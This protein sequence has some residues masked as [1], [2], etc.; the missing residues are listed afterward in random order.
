LQGS[1]SFVLASKLKALKF[2]LKRWNEEV[3][4]NVERKNNILLEKLHVFDVL[5]E[6]R[7]LGVEEK[8]EK[9]EI[10]IEFERSTLME[11]VSYNN[12]Y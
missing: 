3:F 10:I 12:F 8:L 7:A 5:E 1:P 9:V 6:E 4:D 2:D 11:E